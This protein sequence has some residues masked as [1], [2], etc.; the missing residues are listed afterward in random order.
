M[1][2]IV[3]VSVPYIEYSAPPAAPA[4]LKGYLNK[5]G[6]SSATRELNI[7]FK[8]RLKNPETIGEMIGYWT[9]IVKNLTNHSN[10]LYHLLMD[11]YAKELCSMPTRWIGLSVFSMDS[12]VFVL[13]FLPYLVKYRS[14]DCKI[15]LGGHGLTIEFL[16]SAR[17]YID[18][19]IQGEGELALR[20]LLQG[21]F[22]YPGINS[23]GKQIDDLDQLGY[24]DYSDYDLDAGY[25]TWYGNEIMIPITGSRGCVRDCSFCD[26]GAIWNKYKYRSGVSVATEIIYN[27]EKLGFK[28]FYFTDSLINGNVKEL[29]NM[30]RHLTE[31]RTRTG[32]E[33]RWGG[34]WIVRSQR[35]LPKDYYALI[36]SSGGF[37]ITMG[38]ETGSDSVRA[39]MKKH[40]TNKDLDDEMEQ[41]SRHRISCGFFMILGYPTETE[42]DFNDTLRMFS[43]YTKYV[44]DGTIIG[45]AIGRGYDHTPGTPI[46]K[47]INLVSFV[48]PDNNKKWRSNVTNSNYLENIRR[49]LIA[50]KLLNNLEWPAS[51]VE[52][53]LRP[54][55][56]NAEFLFG[57]NDLHMVDELLD[58]KNTDVDPTLLSPTAP[59]EI[60]LEISC[61]GSQSLTWP[62]IDIQI[63]NTL[64]RNIEVQGAQT[65]KYYV[66]DKRKRNLVK[67][68]LTNKDQNDTVVENGVIV[69]DKFVKLIEFKIDGVRVDADQLY[70]HGRVKANGE[71]LKQNGL[72]KNSTYTFYFEN[73]VHRFFIRNRRYYFNEKL[74][75]T[76]FLLEKVSSLFD[77]FITRGSIEVQTPVAV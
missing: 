24:T 25:D 76:K 57:E 75:T 35:G 19:Y 54:V 64:Y 9:R 71:R 5:L 70:L 49:R 46:S 66:P 28:N 52:Y 44:A 45:L 15:L 38:V 11:Q 68:T 74:Q 33:I 40:F 47:D 61:E 39:H 20:E 4:T 55:L 60:E 62:I 8:N 3:L 22:D 29:I 1:F 6:I 31:Y 73:P 50:Q 26:V 41:F 69:G 30:M 34:Q 2:D 51:N 53:E 77:N 63:N 32:A 59:T 67:I 37:N 42:E 27:Y 58:I 17:C 65:F 16:E 23:N 43:R 12:H 7:E 48:N 13:D 18:A 72:Y 56:R 10:N 21:N 14:S 36:K